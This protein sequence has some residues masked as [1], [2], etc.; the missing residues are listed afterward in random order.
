MREYGQTHP[1]EIKEISDVRVCFSNEFLVGR[2]S[3]AT[4]VYVGLS[5]DG[6]ERA[7]KRLPRDDCASL[8]E[9]EKKILNQP[10]AMQSKYVVKYWYLDDESDNDWVFLITDLW[11]ETLNQ[12][13]ERSCWE[14][15]TEIARD[16][17]RQVL[18]GLRDLHCRPVS[19]LHRDLKPSNI[20]RNVHGNWLLAGFGISQILRDDLNTFRSK[21]SGTRGWKAV[22]ACSSKCKSD[23]RYKRKSDIQVQYSSA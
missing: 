17:I 7:V 13:V 8:A 1:Q 16:I 19:I 23:V 6:Y 11:E 2:E 21:P 10:N 3:G 20:L 12:Y 14:G 15:W 4:K 22:E 9:Q 5:R 18:K